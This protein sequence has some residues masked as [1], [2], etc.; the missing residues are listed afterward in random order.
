[1]V[2]V[3]VKVT[4][5]PAQDGLLP[6]VTAIDTAGT[7]TGFTVIVMLFDV[8][9]VGDAHAAFDVSTQVT[10]CPVVSVVVV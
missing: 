4:D 8:A 6:D 3:A 5:A 9:V 10:I 1:M 2:G 7:T